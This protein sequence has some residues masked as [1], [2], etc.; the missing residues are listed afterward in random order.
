[1]DANHFMLDE[2]PGWEAWGQQFE[3]VFRF[4]RNSIMADGDMSKG[5]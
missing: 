4:L 5:H 1:M 2:A 3:K